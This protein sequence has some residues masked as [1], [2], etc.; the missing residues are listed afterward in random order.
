MGGLPGDPVG[1]EAFRHE[2]A[3]LRLQDER[4]VCAVVE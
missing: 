4:V 2:A 1:T 3:L